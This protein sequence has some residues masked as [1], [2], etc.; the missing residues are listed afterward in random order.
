MR[1]T[2]AYTYP[3]GSC[4]EIDV[5]DQI[6][7]EYNPIRASELLTHARDLIRNVV[8]DAAHERAEHEKPAAE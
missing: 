5:Q 6:E 7:D 4:I 8:A 3:D 1:V 2:A